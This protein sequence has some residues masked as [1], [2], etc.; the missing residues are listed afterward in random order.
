MSGKEVS[1]V[2][3]LVCACNNSMDGAATGKTEETEISLLKEGLPHNGGR[4]CSTTVLDLMILLK[5]EL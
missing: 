5:L 1:K 3:M 2:D 4:E